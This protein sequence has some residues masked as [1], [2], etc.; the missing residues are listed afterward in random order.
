MSSINPGDA[1]IRLYEDM[2][3]TDQLDDDTARI[4][5]QWG[6]GQLKMMANTSADEAAFEDRFRDLRGLLK[7]VNRFTGK[8]HGMD[9]EQQRKYVRVL[10]ERAQEAGYP[11]PFGAVA[12]VV[13]AAARL[14]D[15]AMVRGLLMLIETGRFDVPG[16]PN[17]PADSQRRAGRF[18]S[19]LRRAG[20]DGDTTDEDMA[21]GDDAADEA[22]PA[23]EPGTEEPASPFAGFTP[24]SDPDADTDTPDPDDLR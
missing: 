15:A 17:P 10:I 3:L 21:P 5:H 23:N 16:T 7:S 22:K 12:P 19:P 6:E 20:P 18:W 24:D 1:I 8:R 2:S 4:L 14:D 9:L 13:D 11:A